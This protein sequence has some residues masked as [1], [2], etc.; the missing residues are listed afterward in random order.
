MVKYW[1]FKF[2]V[3]SYN[4]NIVNIY[5]LRL[6][7]NVWLL[8]NDCIFIMIFTCLI[9]FW[10]FLYCRLRLSERSRFFSRFCNLFTRFFRYVISRL[11]CFCFFRLFSVLV[12][13]FLEF[14]GS[15][16]RVKRLWFI[17]RSMFNLL[18]RYKKF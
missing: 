13:F 14:L 16:S 6:G 1:N 18:K 5:R 7:F 10:K 12:V 17:K 2:L 8:R 15:F 11:I 4:G 9:F 3:F